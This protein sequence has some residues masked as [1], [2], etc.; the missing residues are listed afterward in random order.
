MSTD[1]RTSVLACG[2]EQF[3]LML[4]NESKDVRKQFKHVRMNNFF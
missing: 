3:L 4:E 1:A 2:D